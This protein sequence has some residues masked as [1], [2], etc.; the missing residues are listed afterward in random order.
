METSVER[1]IQSWNAR[2][3]TSH[4]M[5]EEML[6]MLLELQECASYWSEYYVPCGLVERLDQ[7]IAK[8]KG[9]KA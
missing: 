7:M 3:D 8:A 9:E 4:A 6:S 2:T 5:Q 1:A